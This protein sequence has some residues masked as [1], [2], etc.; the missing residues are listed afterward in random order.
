M[1]RPIWR[2]PM[3]QR[4]DISQQLTH[5][6]KACSDMDA[7]DVLIKILGDHAIIGSDRFVRGGAKCVSLTEAPIE[8]LHFGLTDHRGMVRYS[9]YGLQ[10]PKGAYL[11]ARRSAG[12]LRDRIGVSSVARVSQV[13]PCQI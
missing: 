9:P 13:A 3:K 11:P 7:L 12:N 2:E 6:T 10:F 5:F 1:T 8:T 4:T